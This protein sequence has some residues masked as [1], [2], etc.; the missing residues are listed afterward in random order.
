MYVG[1]SFPPQHSYSFQ[2]I[3]SINYRQIRASLI[4]V[5]RK[6]ERFDFERAKVMATGFLTDLM[7]FDSSELLFI[8]SFN[9][10]VYQR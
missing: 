8:D 7:K 6:Q 5:L 9:Q 4:P 2:S 10:G 1:G 3:H